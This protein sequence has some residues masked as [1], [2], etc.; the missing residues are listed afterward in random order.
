M[1]IFDDE[2]NEIL[3]KTLNSDIRFGTCARC[4]RREDY[5]F[6]IIHEG[7]MYCEDCLRIMSLI[8][9]HGIEE[10]GFVKDYFDFI[11]E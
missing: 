11:E 2:R 6:A 5:V 8:I 10:M 1:H 7:D 4:G 3:N 9:R